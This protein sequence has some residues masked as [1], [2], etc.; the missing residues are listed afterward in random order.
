MRVLDS[1]GFRTGHAYRQP[2]LL[3]HVP[4]GATWAGDTLGD[5]ATGVELLTTDFSATECS[6]AEDIA[7]AEAAGAQQVSR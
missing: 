1:A 4:V 3:R 7:A 2:N 6:A 5:Q